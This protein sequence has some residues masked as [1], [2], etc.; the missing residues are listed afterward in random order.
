[1]T[2]PPSGLC[3][4]PAEATGV[5]DPGIP[6][7]SRDPPPLFH[8]LRHLAFHQ[9]FTRIGVTFQARE[10]RRPALRHASLES[11]ELKGSCVLKRQG[12]PA[13]LPRC[14]IPPQTS[15]Q[16]WRQILWWW[17]GEGKRPDHLVRR[18]RA[19]GD[20]LG[21]GL[22]PDQRRV[23]GPGMVYSQIPKNGTTLYSQD[24]GRLATLL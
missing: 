15:P 8:S 1:M 12:L 24:N 2:S 9:R 14:F 19:G 10:E 17:G 13:W 7:R 5:S 22:C 20:L 11:R 21:S 16:P 4:Q 6:L 18:G 23:P 3:R